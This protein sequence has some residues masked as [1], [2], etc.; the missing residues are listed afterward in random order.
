MCCFATREYVFAVKQKHF[1]AK[2]NPYLVAK[3]GQIGEHV[4]TANVSGNMFSGFARA[5]EIERES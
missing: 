2:N 1:A 3:L 4:S 5:L